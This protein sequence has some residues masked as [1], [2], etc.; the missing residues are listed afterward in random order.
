M[1]TYSDAILPAE[2]GYEI[3][4]YKSLKLIFC[5][6]MLIWTHFFIFIS[7]T[8]IVYYF[9]STHIEYGIVSIISTFMFYIIYFAGSNDIKKILINVDEHTI[10]FRYRLIPFKKTIKLSFE[11]IKEL[12]VNYKAEYYTV[13]ASQKIME[14]NYNVD[15]IDTNLNAYRIYQSTVYNETLKKFAK[16][17]S[18]IINIPLN[19]QNNVEGNKNIFN[20]NII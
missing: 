18:E 8:S 3:K 13:Y 6:G 12:S 11:N 16:T 14:K 9:K 2:N 17:I 7:I 15:I 19:D 20:Q 10:I 1:G 4:N 5:Y